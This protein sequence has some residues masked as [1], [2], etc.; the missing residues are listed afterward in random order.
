MKNPMLRG[1][2]APTGFAASVSGWLHTYL[3]Q[4]RAAGSLTM[5]QLGRLNLIDSCSSL[6][7][8]LGDDDPRV[9]ALALASPGY[10]WEPGPEQ[11]AVVHGAAHKVPGEEQTLKPDDLLNALAH[12]AMLDLAAGHLR[13]LSQV[14]KGV[15]AA[16]THESI[17]KYER[18]RADGAEAQ[19]RQTLE[20]R[21]RAS[22]DYRRE[23]AERR[24]LHAIVMGA[25]P[26]EATATVAA[27]RGLP[28][29]VRRRGD[30]FQGY[31]KRAGE[32]ISQTFDTPEEAAGWVTEQHNQAARDKVV[33]E[34]QHRR[35]DADL[36]S[37]QMAAMQEEA[38]A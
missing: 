12:A 30:R 10:R 17:L 22:A 26:V 19:L 8:G 29:N 15:E 38:A 31:L 34:A 20:E 11:T 16:P 6:P 25:E 7:V 13:E 36:T 32:T 5:S 23:R 21:D 27:P 35:Y 1:N 24:R 3:Y 28:R 2:A 33:S 37:E 9:R 18:E 4:Q 14:K